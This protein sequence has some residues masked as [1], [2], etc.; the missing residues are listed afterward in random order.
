MSGELGQ[1]NGLPVSLIIRTTLQ[2]LESRAGVGTTGGG[3]VM[4]INDVI[5]MAGH[6]HHWLAV[7]DKAT[8]QALDLFRA[9]RT[10]SPAQRIMLI[11][12]DGGCTKPCCT[13]GAY[14][15]QVHHA[16]S[17]WA[18]GG[19]TN[20]NDMTLACGPDNRLVD[21]DGGWTTTINDRGDV[22]WTPPPHL[23]TG[24]TRINYYH[25]PELLLRPPD[26]DR[27]KT[28]NADHRDRR[29][30]PH[31]VEVARVARRDDDNGL[32]WTY[33][34]RQTTRR[35]PRLRRGLRRARGRHD[36]PGARGG[37]GQGR[38]G[39]AAARTEIHGCVADRCVAGPAES[40]PRLRLPRLRMARRARRP[41][42]RRVLRERRQGCR[43]GGDQA[44]RHRRLLRAA[45][46]H[47]PGCTTRVLAVPAGPA[48]R[49]GGA[50]PRRRPLQTH[51]LGRRLP[52]DRRRVT[53][54]SKTPTKR[55]STR[56]DAP[57]TRRRSSTS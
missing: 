25:R 24:Q 2:D 14:G 29:S 55:S 40:A 22:E 11:A 12:R 21:K 5:R 39:V 43:R 49:T 15:A 13:V 57:A 6:A 34:V 30:L 54:H 4:P 20:V 10:A 31:T 28:Q 9:R 32:G 35:H 47:R 46:H 26:D 44:R 7:F 1:L 56:P 3:T 17:D 36:R 27:T 48:H 19:N 18:D 16:L 42:V 45:F 51:Q 33:A 52:L 8:G 50:A 23:D 41:Q 53:R 38:H 37:R